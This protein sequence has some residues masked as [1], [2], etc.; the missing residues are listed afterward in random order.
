ML[1]L[2]AGGCGWFCGVWGRMLDARLSLLMERA[3]LTLSPEPGSAS[4]LAVWCSANGAG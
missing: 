2:R 3:K 4:Q 1:A